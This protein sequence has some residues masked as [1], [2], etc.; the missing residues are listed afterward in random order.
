MLPLAAE[1]RQMRPK[2]QRRR[3]GNQEGF[4]MQGNSIVQTGAEQ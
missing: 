1:Q 4:G 3:F 2:L